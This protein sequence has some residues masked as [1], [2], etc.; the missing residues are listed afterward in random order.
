MDEDKKSIN[1][2]TLAGKLI[3]MKDTMLKVQKETEYR[4]WFN[5]GV[6]QLTEVLR[7]YQENHEEL[8]DQVLMFIV[9]YLNAN[10]GSLFIHDGESNKLGLKACY[11]FNRKKYLEKEIAPGEGLVGQI[12]L[13]KELL[14]LRNLPKDYT[15]I[16]SGLGDSE[17]V[18]LIIVPLINND[19]VLGVMELASF[20]AMDKNTEDFLNK[21]AEVIA[22]S[23]YVYQ[24]NEKTRKLLEVSQLQAEELRSQEEEMRQNS[25]ELQ[26]TQEE[27]TRQKQELENELEELRQ[28]LSY[29]ESN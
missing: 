9:K 10:Q 21:V 25:E 27:M 28:K 3:E 5:N 7:N 17:P 23:L 22:S 4:T 29:A 19:E 15:T 11:A 16:S 6:T 1:D 2:G 14:H 18:T 24:N 12:F 13:E 20:K 8:F 26:A